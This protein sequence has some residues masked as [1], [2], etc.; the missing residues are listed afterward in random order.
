L[1]FLYWRYPSPFFHVLDDVAGIVSW[2]WLFILQGAVTFVIA[3]AGF[4]ILLELQLTTIWLT[5]EECQ[6]AH[7]RMDFDTVGNKGE[8][9]TW[10]DFKSP[11]GPN[12][13]D[14]RIRGKYISRSQWLQELLLHCSSNSK[15]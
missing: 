4:F 9:S 13:L 2:R 15:F 10:K 7:S 12:G 5:P 3:I 11:L 14:L 6:L 8:T 1:P